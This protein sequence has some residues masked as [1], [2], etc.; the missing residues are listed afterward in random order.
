MA[1][2]GRALY[3]SNDAIYIRGITDINNIVSL[4]GMF[5]NHINLTAV[6]LSNLDVSNVT[7]MSKMFKNCRSLVNIGNVTNW[8]T[9]NVVNVASMFEQCMHIDS[10]PLVRYDG[11]GYNW[12]LNNCINFAGMFRNS[13]ILGNVNVARLS[14]SD[15]NLCVMF[16]DSNI[17][18]SVTMTSFNLVNITNM[19]E[20]FAYSNINR[21]ALPNVVLNGCTNISRMFL[22]ATINYMRISKYTWRRERY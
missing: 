15:A 22:N 16:R 19:M 21:L 17:S 13:R 3:A 7:S 10:F 11:I 12:D 14:D 1:S 18:D 5:E 2:L 4:D 6:N 9:S 8:S 20:M